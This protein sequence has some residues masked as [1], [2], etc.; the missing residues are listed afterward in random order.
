MVLRGRKGD[1]PVL[2]FFLKTHKLKNL[3]IEWKRLIR[4]TPKMR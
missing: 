2:Q 1:L 4:I 3:T